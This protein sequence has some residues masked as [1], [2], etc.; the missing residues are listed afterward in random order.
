MPL[1]YHPACH[2]LDGHELRLLIPLTPAT[3]SSP[4]RD[5]ILVHDGADLLPPWS[6]EAHPDLS[7]LLP[8]LAA[9]HLPVLA[10]ICPMNRL[11]QYTP[12][13]APPLVAER[14]PF[15]GK[16][17]EYRDW[18]ESRLLPWLE[19][20]EGCR[21]S[22]IGTMGASLGGLVSLW[23]QAR[24][25][26]RYSRAACLSPSV[27]YPG[28]ADWLE[29]RLAPRAAPEGVRTW[30]SMGSTETR[31]KSTI[32]KHMP[33][34]FHNVSHT[35]EAWAPGQVQAVVIP[36]RTHSWEFFHECRPRALDWICSG[37]KEA[38]HA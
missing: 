1:P 18:L 13:P 32:Q 27:W 36:D 10:G 4:G 17:A 35:L 23:L 31:G 37:G 26:V 15:E 8:S 29:A 16:A 2:T 22:G 28:L 34:L 3:P 21:T 19:S 25:P 20:C 24:D 7:I 33:G 6:K 14:P 12:W 30:L 38:W 5:L 11:N 9:E